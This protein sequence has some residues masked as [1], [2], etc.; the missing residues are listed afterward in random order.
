[1]R[2]F[3]RSLICICLVLANLFYMI[4]CNETPSGPNLPGGDGYQTQRSKWDI[5]FDFDYIP[6]YEAP[7]PEG[8]VLDDEFL[9][10]TYRF[11]GENAKY[12]NTDMQFNDYRNLGFDLRLSNNLA[13]RNLNTAGCVGEYTFTAN[14][15]N[16]PLAEL[17]DENGNPVSAVLAEMDILVSGYPNKTVILQD[18]VDI[19]ANGRYVDLSGITIKYEDCEILGHNQYMAFKLVTGL[20]VKI[21]NGENTIKFTSLKPDSGGNIDYI[22]IRTAAIIS[23]WDDNYYPDQDSIWEIIKEPTLEETGTL[24][25]TSTYINK[26]GEEQTSSQNYTLP[27]L[28]TENGYDLVETQEPGGTVY[29]YS[30]K[31]KGV[32]YSFEYAPNRR[33]ELKLAED[34]G[35]MFV[36]QDGEPTDSAWLLTDE[37]MPEIINSTGKTIAGWYNVNNEEGV[38]QDLWVVEG[39]PIANFDEELRT[40]KM[41]NR[42]LTIAPFFVG[43]ENVQALIPGTF[44]VGDHTNTVIVVPEE[45]GEPIEVPTMVELIGNMVI[46]GEIGAAFRYSGAETGYFR[47]VAVSGPSGTARGI[48]GGCEYTF[49]YNFVNLGEEDITFTAYQLQSQVNLETATKFVDKVTLEPGENLKTFVNL[50]L[51]N[52]N[53]NVMTLIVLDQDQEEA[54][55]GMTMSKVNKSV[56]TLSLAEDCGVTFE[57]GITSIQLVAGESLPNFINQTG[58]TIAGWYNVD[59]TSQFWKKTPYDVYDKHPNINNQNGVKVSDFAM[60]KGDTTIAP[61]FIEDDV[62]LLIPAS[63]QTSNASTGVSHSRKT[64]I[65][66]TDLGM[67]L[68]AEVSYAGPQDGYFRLT[69]ICGSSDTDQMAIAAGGTYTFNFYFKNLGNETLKFTAYQVQGGT[70]MDETSKNTGLITLEPGESIRTSMTITLANK[71]KNALTVIKLEQAQTNAKLGVVMTKVDHVED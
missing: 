23:D 34:C 71:N 27:T 5:D 32:T 2:K 39:R 7:E 42:G 26:D 37:E 17:K 12:T 3:G 68:G 64:I 53:A 16:T 47:L 67:Q 29:I 58:K 31:L 56:F 13:T 33:Y 55:L 70:T 20:K 36:G 62:Q 61:F 41:P 50:I 18:I 10:N 1:M 28:S 63:S 66:E 24:R 51:D 25:V 40:F 9:T 19:R 21:V 14:F 59:N 8:I 6:R 4:G 65:F 38:W 43:E 15:A 49:N 69:T 60:P 57:D 54:V 44:R 48:V 52:N 35:V 11:E 45:G 46:D 22:D 30:F